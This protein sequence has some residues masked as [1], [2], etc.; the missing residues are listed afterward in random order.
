M[1]DAALWSL[2]ISMSENRGTPRS[3]LIAHLI[4]QLLVARKEGD[5][6]RAGALA[7]CAETLVC[8]AFP[9]AADLIRMAA[10]RK[11]RGEV[12]ATRLAPLLTGTS[13][14]LVAVVL[15]LRG[16]RSPVVDGLS[17]VFD[18][19]PDFRSTVRKLCWRAFEPCG[20]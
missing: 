6:P 13:A 10:A 2:T 20:N 18:D 8:L 1:L 14:A 9:G 17:C 16:A 15:A 19:D 7:R 12:V 5:Y 3:E 11:G 4:D